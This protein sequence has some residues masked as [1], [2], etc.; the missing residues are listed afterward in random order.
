[1][2]R[3][4]ADQP[5]ER[6]QQGRDEEAR[7]AA[8][9]AVGES[10]VVGFDEVEVHDGIERREDQ[11]RQHLAAEGDDVR[12]EEDHVVGPLLGE[13]VSDRQP[14]G[15]A[16]AR[17]ADRQPG[18]LQAAQETRHGRRLAPDDDQSAGYGSK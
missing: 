16:L 8:V 9:E 7:H 10:G 18:V 5:G 1:M 4:L 17:R 2:Y 14:A 6:R 12:V 15:A 13:E 11:A 3:V